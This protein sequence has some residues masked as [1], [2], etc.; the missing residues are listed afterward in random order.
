MNKNKNEEDK[1]GKRKKK[2]KMQAKNVCMHYR[3]KILNF[4]YYFI[5]STRI[6]PII[7]KTKT[8]P[9]IINFRLK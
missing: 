8:L 5:L 1:V 9:C 2:K 4:E 7:I 6:L 3:N